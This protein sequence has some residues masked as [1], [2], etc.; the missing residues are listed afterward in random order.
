[1]PPSGCSI[2]PGS[3]ITQKDR[4]VIATWAD[5]LLW[6]T[7]RDLHIDLLHTGPIHRA[8]GVTGT[9]YTPTTDGWFDPVSL[10]LDP[11]IGS[12]AEYEELAAVAT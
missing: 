2:T 7:L 10:D 8:G 12:E 5:P 6:D 9:E 1:M 11:A 4:S 3:V